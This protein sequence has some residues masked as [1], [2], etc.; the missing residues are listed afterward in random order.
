MTTVSDTPGKLD[1]AQEPDFSLGALLVSPSSGRVSGDGSDQRVEPRVMEVLVL[2]V[3][4]QGR[5]V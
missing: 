2:L 5:T 4:A 3:R 1:L